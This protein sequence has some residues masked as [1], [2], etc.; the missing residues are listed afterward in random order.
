MHKNCLDEVLNP[1]H[2]NPVVPKLVCT[3]ST[4]A[5]PKTRETP[6]SEG[7]TQTLGVFEVFLGVS[8]VQNHFG[9][10]GHCLNPRGPQLSLHSRIAW[11]S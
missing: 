3:S 2:T 10:E 1:G 8:N 11:M 4:E 9:G 7:G 5:T 6:L